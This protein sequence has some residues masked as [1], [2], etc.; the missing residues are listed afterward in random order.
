MIDCQVPKFMRLFV[1]DDQI[2]STNINA[3]TLPLGAP[4]ISWLT[5]RCYEFENFL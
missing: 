5:L 2:F 1:Y 3:L 4:D